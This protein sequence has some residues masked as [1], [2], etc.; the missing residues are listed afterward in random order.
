MDVLDPSS[1]RSY[2]AVDFSTIAP[3]YLVYPYIGRTESSTGRVVELKFSQ[4]C[5][6]YMLCR[7]LLDVFDR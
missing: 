5:R 1:H 6:F 3:Q 2:A 4:R 7:D